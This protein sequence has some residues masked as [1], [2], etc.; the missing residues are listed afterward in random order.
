M[1]VSAQ[2]T[3]TRPTG[4]PIESK[5][6]I[7]YLDGLIACDGRATFEV[8]RRIGE[9]R[10]LFKRLEKVWKLANVCVQ[11]KVA[12]YQPWIVAKVM[13]SLESVWLLQTDKSCVDAFHCQCL[14]RSHRIA[15]SFIFKI[16]NNTIL[17]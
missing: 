6:S 2:P 13:Y 4:E 16:S 9:G 15:P 17:E 1:G 12:I 3:I 11:R 14:R 7:V 5:C 8:I 10:A